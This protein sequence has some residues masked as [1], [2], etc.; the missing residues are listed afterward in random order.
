MGCKPHNS[1]NSDNRLDRPV[2]NGW[3]SLFSI[4]EYVRFPIRPDDRFEGDLKIDMD[5]MEDLA[6]V[7]AQRTG[8]PLDRCQQNPLCGK[9]KTVRDLVEFFIHQPRRSPPAA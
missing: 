7:I 8:R 6:E 4:S 3:L 1:K 5:D 9:V 2:K